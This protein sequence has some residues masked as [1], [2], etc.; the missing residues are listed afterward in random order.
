MA[1][2]VKGLSPSRWRG[3][4]RA[5]GGPMTHTTLYVLSRESLALYAAGPKFKPQYQQ[6]KE[7][8]LDLKSLAKGI[9]NAD[10]GGA[11]SAL[12]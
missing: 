11:Q 3:V 4:A 2:N 7:D 8:R 9:S 6:L 5:N 12:V 1:E 10:R